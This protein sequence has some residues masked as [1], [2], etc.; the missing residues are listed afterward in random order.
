MCTIDFIK[1]FMLTG[2]VLIIFSACGS[3]SDD[4]SKT[5][6]L[7]TPQTAGIETPPMPG[8]EQQKN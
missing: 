5:S 8:L 3:G 1:K 7:N 2:I 6:A 4:S